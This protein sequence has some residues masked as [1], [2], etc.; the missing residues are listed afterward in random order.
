MFGE[1]RKKTKKKKEKKK[2][3]RGKRKDKKEKKQRK[4]KKEKKEKR[5]HREREK[6]TSSENG[7]KKRK[8]DKLEEPFIL[9]PETQY[10]PSSSKRAKR[11]TF[12]DDSWENQLL[13]DASSSPSHWL[14][15][16]PS[17]MF[18]SEGPTEPSAVTQKSSSD[19]SPIILSDR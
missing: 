6:K 3:K 17:T 15:L 5:H 7:E 16:I 14:P 1:E 9:A 8:L 11:V 10:Y 4:D 18:H 12:K 13:P 19:F 2:E